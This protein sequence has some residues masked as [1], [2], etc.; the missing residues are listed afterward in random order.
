MKTEIKDYKERFDEIYLG[1][2]GDST[3][4]KSAI[5]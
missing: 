5:N 1:V 4:E 3:N 2:S